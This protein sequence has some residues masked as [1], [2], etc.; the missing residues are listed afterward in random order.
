MVKKTVNKVQSVFL[1]ALLII[2][3][4][5]PGMSVFAIGAFAYLFMELFWRGHSH[6]TMF[7]AGG[8]AGVAV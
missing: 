5:V 6:I 8:I 1:S 7:F 4:L 3:T 2:L